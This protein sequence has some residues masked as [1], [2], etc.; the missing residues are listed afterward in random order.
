MSKPTEIQ[1]VQALEEIRTKENSGTI[2]QAIQNGKSAGELSNEI[3]L[4]RAKF[5]VD[6]SVMDTV[7]ES[8]NS[9]PKRHQKNSQSDVP[10]QENS[11]VASTGNESDMIAAAANRHRQNK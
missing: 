1:R 6:P 11:E 9:D 3:L 5:G 4:S 2:D 10:N 7:I 8:I